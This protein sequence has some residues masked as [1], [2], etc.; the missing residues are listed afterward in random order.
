ME[1]I[2]AHIRT[3]H[4]FF[5]MTAT[6]PGKKNQLFDCFNTFYHSSNSQGCSC[7]QI[8]FNSRF[9]FLFKM[10]FGFFLS[11]IAIVTVGMAAIPV[12]QISIPSFK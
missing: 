1:R 8:V 6:K 3:I 12:S 10:K 4:T 11:L 2:Y 9:A 7:Q 5:W